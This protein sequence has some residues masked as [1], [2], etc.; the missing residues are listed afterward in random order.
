VADVFIDGVQYAPVAD[1]SPSIGVAVTTR[2]RPDILKRCREAWGK[3]LPAGAV[4][5]IV[6]D[7]SAKPVDSATYRFDARAGIAGAKNKCLELL[8]DAG[9]DHLFLFDDDCWPK[10]ADWWRPYVE[11]REQ[12]FAHSWGLAELYRDSEMVATHASGGTMLYLT[13]DVVADCG[14]YQTDMGKYG[15]EHWNLSDRIFSRGWTSFRYQDIPEATDGKL[16]YELDR[17]EK[18]TTHSTA[19]KADKEYDQGTGRKV[20]RDRRHDTEFVPWR[21]PRDVILTDLYVK[22]TDPQRGRVTGL[23]AQA[24]ERLETSVDR[25]LVIFT[26]IDD[27][28][29]RDGVEWVPSKASI[30]LDFQRWLNVSR[31][32]ADH[33]DIDRVWHVDAT[34]V[35][36]TRSP[37]G[38]MEPGTLYVG[39]EPCTIDSPWLKQMHPDASILDMIERHPDWQMLNAGVAGGDRDLVA[40]LARA[41]VQFY[42]DDHI[43]QVQRWET[44]L[45]RTDMGPFNWVCRNLF[46]GVISHGPHVTNIFKSD[47]PGDT[48]WWK[49]K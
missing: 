6:D 39:D 4:L 33:P 37:W 15:R 49:H 25:P 32:L 29:E 23:T 46:P 38:R 26:D 48:S 18:N 47:K 27:P 42:C 35:I 45:A 28:P 34:D 12:H 10:V 8:M 21:P 9:V 43:D 40:G 1:S 19:T 22:A 24:V 2:D 30:G 17:Y 14:G 5:V 13:R 31:W 20:W 7:A 36:M 16:F 44:D 41:I 3:F 11:S